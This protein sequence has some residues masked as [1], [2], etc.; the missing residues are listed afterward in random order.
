[1]HSVS[2]KRCWL[3]AT[4]LLTVFTTSVIYANSHFDSPSESNGFCYGNSRSSVYVK[5]NSDCDTKIYCHEISADNGIYYMGLLR[6][7]KYARLRPSA[8]NA[9]VFAETNG[10]EV[11]SITLDECRLN[12]SLYI[13]SCASP[14]EGTIDKISLFDFKS[15]NSITNLKD[16]EIY[17]L[18]EL[19]TEFVLA[20]IIDGEAESVLFDVNDQQLAKNI[21]PFY[22]PSNDE[23]WK[24]LAGKYAIKAMVYSDNF[25]RGIKCDEKQINIEF[26]DTRQIPCK[27]TI[28]DFKLYDTKSLETIITLRDGGEYSLKDFPKDFGLGVV[29]DGDIGSMS[30]DINDGD[31]VIKNEPPYTYPG[32]GKAWH[33]EPGTYKITATSYAG[34]ELQGKKCNSKT[35][36]FK[37]I[38]KNECE[39]VISAAKF[40]DLK[41]NND[42]TISD[43]ATY[44][45]I[46]LPTLYNIE[47]IAIGEFES[48]RFEI[49]GTENEF[50]TDNGYPYCY[51]A[52]DINPVSLVPGDYTLTIKVFS[53]RRAVGSVC[54]VKT[55]S[56][57]VEA[58]P[59]L[60]N[61]PCDDGNQETINDRVNEDD[62]SCAGVC[63]E[64]TTE[65]ETEISFCIDDPHT[66]K[67]FT[68][69]PAAIY[70]LVE[71]VAYDAPQ[72]DPY[73]PVDTPFVRFLGATPIGDGN[74]S[75]TP[76][77]GQLSGLSGTYYAYV[78]FKPEPSTCLEFVEYVI[79]IE[80]DSDGDGV[81]DGEDCKPSDPTFPV[82]PFAT[83][84]DGDQETINDNFGEAGCECMGICPEITTEQETEIN[85]CI[86]DSYTFEVA[87]NAP[88]AVYELL[89]IVAY[90]APQ[91]DPYNPVGNP[92][93]RF[94]GATPIGD[95]NVSI[96]PVLGQLNGLSG[97][98]YAYVCFKPEPSTCLE[99]VEYVITIEDDSDG[100]GI[101]D[102]ND[103]QPNDPSLPG[104]A[105]SACN[106]G[107]IETIGDV[108]GDDG[109]SCAGICPEI[110][111]DQATEISF[112]KEDSY[113]F[114]VNTNAP[115]AIYDLVEIVAYDTPQVD[116]YNPVGN[117]FVR[118]LGA[119]PIGD[120]NVS[121]TPVQGQL[122][123][124]SGTYYAYVCFKPEPITCLEYV[125]YVI[126][127]EDDSDG[128]GVCDVND[129]HPN[130]PALPG[131]PGSAC[132]DGNLGT[133]NDIVGGDG[134]SCS[135]SC[136]EI[137]TQQD[138]II[139][140][141][142]RG[143]FT[144]EVVTA[145]SVNVSDLVEIVVYDKPQDDPYN[146]IGNPFKRVIG[147]APIGNGKVSITPDPVKIRRLYGTY[148]L[149]ICF[150]TE[151]EN[152]TEHV[153]YIADI[154]RCTG[155]LS[156]SE[157]G[158]DASSSSTISTISAI[159]SN[160][161]DS[162]GSDLNSEKEGLNSGLKIYQNKPNPFRSTTDIAFELPKAGKVSL[163]LTDLTGK[164]TQMVDANFNSGYN[165]IRLDRK[166]LTSGIYYYTLRTETGQVSKKLVIL[167]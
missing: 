138:T 126:T 71:I 160:T 41:G 118:F 136:P 77:Q 27:G 25:G 121:I 62:C 18:D 45:T 38:D 112:C 147:E 10:I 122:S 67:V 73:N 43:G 42:I 153:K 68:N 69:A 65:Q 21:K 93:V 156:N 37:V 140:F 5:N 120:G 54:D 66:F 28:S 78:C 46:D 157:N 108:I 23:A 83:C 101:C 7:G 146:P 89:E 74:V 149:Y 84:D 145:T 125:E 115:A 6:P 39:A 88:A 48:I 12:K 34:N 19:P 100:D 131:I 132:D 72:V 81:C 102:I 59:L 11:A 129:C 70:D 166:N 134:C 137:T 29:I 52:G 109:C 50:Y 92:F 94:L 111:T 139:S 35:I 165:K 56:F 90:D 76:E 98:Y 61:A 80:E 91:V 95:G 22:F 151:P 86:E 114:K 158:S 57:S 135:G 51:P 9:R 161:F 40:N 2:T 14:C 49:S 4:L 16:G 53:R 130:D 75:I 116:P 20:A 33:P 159:T 1:M 15:F 82:T 103:C 32:D 144:F 17:Y 107:N 128:D 113:T 3:I 124:L 150:K 119:T 117:P 85:F 143:S 47:A 142:D 152:C 148:Y 26:K 24:V 127:I 110:S 154:Q 123:G 44:S 106:D 167:D 162:K 13:N 60:P 64:I 79:T 8:K 155:F 58:C 30:F 141:C 104:T 96:T 133:Y 163:L 87:T 164:T 97:T 105:G 36:T 63:P 99:F 31:Q 55:I